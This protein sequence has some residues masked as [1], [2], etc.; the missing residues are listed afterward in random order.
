MVFL[1]DNLIQR[2]MVI[3][4]DKNKPPLF[5]TASVS[6]NFY[7]FNFLRLLKII[8]KVMF[9]GVF[10]NTSVMVCI[11]LDQGVAPSEGVALLE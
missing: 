11:S 6:H 2:V 10:F 9:F 1:K 7:H 4:G 5:P 8:S 3:K